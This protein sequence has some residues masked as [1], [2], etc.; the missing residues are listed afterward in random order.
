MRR[1]ADRTGFGWVV[2]RDLRQRGP[3]VLVAVVLAVVVLVGVGSS[4]AASPG[5]A[6]GAPF[7][8]FAR[9]TAAG[10]PRL[11]CDQLAV[12][13]LRDGTPRTRSVRALREACVVSLS[14][15]AADLDPEHRHSLAGTRVVQVRVRPGRARVTVQTTLYGVQPR[16]T[17]AAVV[18]DGRWKIAEQP[19]GAHVDSSLIEQI[20]SESMVPTLHAGDTALVDRAAYRRAKPQIGDIVVFHPPAGAQR[21]KQCARRPPAGQACATATPR[22]S[23]AKFVKR[24]V[25]APGDRVA[26]RRGHVIR[27]G[28][29]VK[30]GF[31]APCSRGEGCDF[32]RTLTV[33]AGSY[34]VLGDNRGASDDS[35][36][37]GPVALESIIG[38]VRRLGP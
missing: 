12:T 9:A 24:I 3:V 16:S 6:A 19:S 15:Q 28:T 38:R 25:A 2:V 36:Y 34:Y 13:L 31:V 23:T 21:E 18:E 33:T 1:G 11:A 8:T 14:A 35:R 7:V 27:N 37:W 32:P 4:G 22:N 5:D 26:I 17:G 20:P 10:D 29:P 30:E